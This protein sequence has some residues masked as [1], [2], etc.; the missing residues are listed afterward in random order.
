VHHASAVY[1]GDGKP[2]AKYAAIIPNQARMRETSTHSMA[3]AEEALR[4]VCAERIHT[5]VFKSLNSDPFAAV[6]LEEHISDEEPIP[7][8]T[9][10]LGA[11]VIDPSGRV[12]DGNNDPID[13]LHAADPRGSY[14]DELATALVQ[15]L[16]MAESV[17]TVIASSWGVSVTS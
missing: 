13:C 2:D 10:S 12:L 3:A 17:A 1:H 16:L 4:C 15:G 14:F 9:H 7:E 5:E 11:A 8:I 6:V